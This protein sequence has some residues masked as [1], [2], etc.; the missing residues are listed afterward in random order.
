MSGKENIY[1]PEG[2]EDFSVENNGRIEYIYQIKDITKSLKLSDISSPNK[3]LFI[4]RVLN[5]KRD[6]P[7]AKIK[8]IHFGE[9]VVSFE[10]EHY[11]MSG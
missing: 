11:T 8:L 2:I 5:Y 7:H 3:K 4:A 6:F 10:N 1:L 9:L